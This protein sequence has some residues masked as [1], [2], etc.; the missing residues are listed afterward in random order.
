MYKKHF[1]SYLKIGLLVG[2]VT[3]LIA[4]LGFV[5]FGLMFGHEI[6]LVGQDRD[7]LYIVFISFATFMAVFFSSIIFYFLQKF[8]KKPVLWFV[9]VVVLGFLFN[10]YTAEVDLQEQYKVTAHILHVLVSALA[11]YFVPKFAKE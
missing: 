6:S 1:L 4:N 10:T 9:V 8:S 5:I 3:A 11:V 7:T 2:L